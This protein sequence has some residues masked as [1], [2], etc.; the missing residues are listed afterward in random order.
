MCHSKS[1]IGSTTRII[2]AVNGYV[3][4]IMYKQLK[5]VAVMSKW[6]NT[7]F[8]L[9]IWN[10]IFDMIR[11]SVA[12][13]SNGLSYPQGGSSIPRKTLEPGQILIWWVFATEK[14]FNP[15]DSITISL[16]IRRGAQAA[17]RGHREV[18]PPMQGGDFGFDLGKCHYSTLTLNIMLWWVFAC[19]VY[20][21]IFLE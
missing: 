19:N 16:R 8:S 21:I 6:L 4:Y 7:E 3:K 10:M 1:T 17:G 13:G 18:S 2:W 12:P 15:L 5:F 11:W 14:I 20:F 9:K